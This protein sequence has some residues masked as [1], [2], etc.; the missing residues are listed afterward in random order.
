MQ[1]VLAG[2]KPADGEI[3]LDGTVGFGGHAKAILEALGPTGRLIGLDKDTMALEATHKTL[4]AYGDHVMLAHSS[5]ESFDRI[6]DEAEVTEVDGMLLDLGVS[7]AQLDIAE[8]GF[9]FNQDGPLDMRMDPDL[10]QSATDIINKW[11]AEELADLIYEFGE[12]R[13]SRRYARAIVAA[14][15]E[16]P[17]VRTQQLADIIRKA[18]PMRGHKRIHPA[19]RTFQALRIAVNQELADL[20][21]FLEKFLRF[22]KPNGRIAI[23]AYHSLEDRRVKRAFRTAAQQGELDILT[24]RPQ[25]PSDEEIQENPRSRSAKL[26]I[27]QRADTKETL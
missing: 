4:E 19:T 3:F 15:Q 5:F 10:E 6:L 2:L 22:L 8:R 26:R 21:A 13:L 9:S 7:S 23:L 1:E 18:T 24:K 11:P 12:E 17:I 16:E 14:R 25:T 27:A 20:D